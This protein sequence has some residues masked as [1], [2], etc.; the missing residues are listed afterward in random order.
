M[1]EPVEVLL[2]S[3]YGALGA[4]SRL[5]HLQYLPALER[6]GVRVTVAPFFDDDH[7]QA[8]YAGRRRPLRS[9]LA[10]YG[11]RLL[12]LWNGRRFD[13][14]WVEKELLPWLPYWVERL[15][16][17]R[18]PYVV[19]YDDAWFH[20][21]DQHPRPLVRALFGRRIDRVMRDAAVVVAGNT[22]LAER[23][24]AAGAARIEI[25][26]TVVDLARY[27]LRERN[28]EGGTEGGQF[29]ISW[30]GTPYTARYLPRIA[31][32]LAAVCA[33][34]RA[35]VRLIGAGP[36][37]LP[38]VP[39]EHR[40]WSEAGEVAEIQA[41]DVGIMPLPDEPFERGKCGYKLIQYMAAGR[42]V[43]ASPVGVNR[44]LVQDGVNGF[45]A[46]TEAEWTAALIRL[47]DDP[48]LRRAMGDAGRRR[49]ER[50]Y[51]LEVTAARLPG[52]LRTACSLS[53]HST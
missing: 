15:A 51:A 5:R 20:R 8:F 18:V 29:T 35:V 26:P 45:L 3:R 25:V 4:S 37:D 31:G 36:V 53:P 39:V 50:D 9:V 48:A 38:G 6:A 46:V 24:R 42:P 1:A 14:L 12:R 10:C 21:Y 17:G 34:G 11:R 32:P 7:V 13:L 47:R 19:D 27:P 41:G 40:R 43:V 49:V 22:Y 30:I 2:L 16:R 44:E 33:E 28:D 23:A 52:I